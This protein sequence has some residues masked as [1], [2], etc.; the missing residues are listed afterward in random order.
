ME[1]LLLNLL[2]NEPRIHQYSVTFRST[3]SAEWFYILHKLDQSR[4]KDVRYGFVKVYVDHDEKRGHAE[5]AVY[6]SH[7]E[8]DIRQ[9]IDDAIL[10]ASL[11]DN[12]PYVLP[13]KVSI[14]TPIEAFDRVDFGEKLIDF[15]FAMEAKY[16][17]EINSFEVFVNSHNIRFVNSN[18]T[19]VRYANHDSLIELIVNANDGEKEIELMREWRLAAF[20][21]QQLET[22]FEELFREA[23]DRSAAKPTPDLKKS[24]L[25]L[26][27]D[28]VKQLLGVYASVTHAQTVFN[29]SSPY[30]LGQ[31]MQKEAL[32]DRLTITM[33]DTLSASCAN[34]PI[35][36]DGVALK[37][38]TIVESGVFKNVWGDARHCQYAKVPIT[39]NLKNMK[40]DLGTHPL[41]EIEAGQVLEVLDFSSFVVDEGSGDFGGEI[42]LGYVLENGQRRPISGGSVSGNLLELHTNLRLSDVG[43]DLDRFSGPQ[44][45]RIADVTVSGIN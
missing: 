26:S 31:E 7:T 5:F 33:T 41:E 15:T 8:A 36:E 28:N 30:E 9:L 42:R 38:V 23:R 24:D 22:R 34:A 44:K 6:P 4:R 27:G 37:S 35:D 29:H 32:G 20:D 12:P 2:R 1:E 13:E 43:Q 40:V 3:Q 11:I 21:K 18:G 45:I 16:H 14:E 10:S 17:G 39:G 25:L 19:D